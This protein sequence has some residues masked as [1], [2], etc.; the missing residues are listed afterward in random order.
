M[1][2]SSSIMRQ[3]LILQ[4]RVL[5]AGQFNEQ[6]ETWQDEA[7]LCG[8]Y[9]PLKGREFWHNQSLPQRDAQA[10]ARIRIRYRK[11]INP[12]WHRILYNN[13]AHDIIAPPIHD[14]RHGQTQ[15]L[16]RAQAT[17]QTDGGTVND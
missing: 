7:L 14:R 13:I 8:S 15:L 4:Y 10:D 11:G 12:A 3:R 6:M 17:A 2:S 5:I 1:S 16:V 9:E